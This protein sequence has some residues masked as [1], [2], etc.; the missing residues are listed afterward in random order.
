MGKI[1]YTTWRPIR[2]SWWAMQK[3]KNK[4]SYPINDHT[5]NWWINGFHAHK[6]EF[7]ICTSN[8]KKQVHSSKWMV[9]VDAIHADSVKQM[10][11]ERWEKMLKLKFYDAHERKRRPHVIEQG[12]LDVLQCIF[13]GSTYV[14][15]FVA[16]LYVCYLYTRTSQINNIKI[17]PNKKKLKRKK[18]SLHLCCR[19]KLEI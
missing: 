15:I 13:E 12:S 7:A 3:K 17:E 18:I 6:T 10:I 8:I 5:S 2:L 19:I 1:T 16:P 9:F 14:E 11:N 4:C